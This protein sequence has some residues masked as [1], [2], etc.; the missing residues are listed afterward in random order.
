MR[1]MQMKTST[2]LVRE[3]VSIR[4]RFEYKRHASSAV[5]IFVTKYR[6]ALHPFAQQQMSIIGPYAARVNHTCDNATRVPGLLHAPGIHL[7]RD[8]LSS[9]AYSEE[10]ISSTISAT[11]QST[12]RHHGIVGHK[13]F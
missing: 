4:K 9:I 2:F 12:D 7:R 8:N 11:L 3:K 10:L 6:G 5:S 13:R 1:F